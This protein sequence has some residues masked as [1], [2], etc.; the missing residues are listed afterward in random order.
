[1]TQEFG[2]II[3]D[4]RTLLKWKPI[5]PMLKEFEDARDV[6]VKFRAGLRVLEFIADVSDAG[7]R[8]RK[9]LAAGDRLCAAMAVDPSLRESIEEL[10]R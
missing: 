8:G 6:T 5:L 7:G 4:A 3:D 2:G 9:L 1:M 10:L